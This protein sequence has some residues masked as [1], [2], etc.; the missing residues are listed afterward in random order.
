MVFEKYKGGCAYVTGIIVMIKGPDFFK[1]GD[2][3]T[4]WRLSRQATCTS[5]EVF[6][7]RGFLGVE[8]RS[9][10]VVWLWPL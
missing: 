10:R 8:P 7:L 4:D 3:A 5:W 1:L 9:V 2:N 6:W